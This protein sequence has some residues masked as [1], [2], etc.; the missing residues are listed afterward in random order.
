[1]PAEK[2]RKYR[3]EFDLCEGAVKEA[4]NTYPKTANGCTHCSNACY[5]S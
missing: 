1:M 4:K 5:T 3:G 2:N